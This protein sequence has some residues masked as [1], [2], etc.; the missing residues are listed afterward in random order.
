MP[1]LP[2]VEIEEEIYSYEPADNGA[3]PLWCHGSTIVARRDS[4]VYVAALETLPGQK[5]L[6][7]CRWSLYGRRGH[8][9]QLLHRDSAGRTREPSPIA[10]LGNGDLLVSANP[11]LSAPGTYNG[12]A[13]PSI[14]RFATTDWSA[15]PVRELPQ[16]QGQPA[17]TEHSYRTVSADR[18]ND[19]VLYMQNVGYDVAH[20]SFLGRE[21]KWRGLGTLAWPWGGE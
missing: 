8:G 19:E 9:W 17:F 13:E 11:T 16:W 3:G 21:G 20:L 5:P 10:L 4:E 15:A 2:V 18:D 7:N 14:A 1:I 12:P 6:N